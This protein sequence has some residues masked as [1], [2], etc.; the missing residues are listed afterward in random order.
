MT[1]A[2]QI[3]AARDRAGLTQKQLA[4]RIG[5]SGPTIANAECG[6]AVYLSTLEK[7]AATLGTTFVIGGGSDTGSRP[8]NP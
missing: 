1:I 4:E 5:M 6:R 7:I 3:F 8:K 2:D